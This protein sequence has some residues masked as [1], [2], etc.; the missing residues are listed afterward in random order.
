METK[1]SRSGIHPLSI[2]AAIFFA[3]AVLGLVYLLVRLTSPE[4]PAEQEIPTAVL[5]MIPAPT[6]TPTPPPTLAAAEET[7]TAAP[8]LPPGTIWVGTYVK[9]S[10]TGGAGLRMRAEPGTEAEIHFMAMDEEV[11]LV[12]GGPEEKDGYVWWQLKA[13]YDANRTGWSAESF[14]SLIETATPTP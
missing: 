5:T 9:V 8:L 4:P 13:S 7:Q 2:L 6:H 14:L 1:P 12:I 3:A 10:G 11:F